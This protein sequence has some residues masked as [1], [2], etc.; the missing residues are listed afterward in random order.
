MPACQILRGLSSYTINHRYVIF[1]QSNLHFSLVGSLVVSFT[2]SA[3]MFEKH[4]SPWL[5]VWIY[6]LI[7]DLIII[8]CSYLFISMMCVLSAGASKKACGK[9]RNCCLHFIN[10]A[11]KDKVY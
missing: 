11:L 7:L 1:H 10:Q 6:A 3:G 9:C 2:L 8:E 4:I 5:M